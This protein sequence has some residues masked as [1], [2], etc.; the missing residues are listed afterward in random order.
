MTKKIIDLAISIWKKNIL[1]IKYV[2]I[3]FSGVGLD[4]LTFFAITV[5]TPIHYQIANIFSVTIGITNN[6]FLN[7]YFNF[8]VKDK[9]LNRFFKFYSIGLIGLG[10]SAGILYVLI[11]MFNFQEL[12]SK[13][14]V[15]VVV[16][17]L[18]FNLNKYI[19]FKETGS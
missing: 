8:K 18:Q 15:I 5:Y 13:A 9:L 1:F 17:I 6:F 12:A 2:L 10:I 3:G 7:A 14:I 19:T 16:S 11:E 4:F